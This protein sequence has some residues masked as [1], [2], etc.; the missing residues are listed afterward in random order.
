MLSQASPGASAFL[1]AVPSLPEVSLSTAEMRIS[2]R[3][4]LRLPVLKNIL[5]W[6]CTCSPTRHAPALWSD[7]LLTCRNEGMLGQR[8]D[9]LRRT[10]RG[11]ATTAGLI[12]EE[13]PRGLPGFG[14]GGGDLLVHDIH[15]GQAIVADVCVVSE[16]IDALAE[17]ASCLAG[18]AAKLAEHRK[19]QKYEP[20][21]QQLGLRFLPLAIESDGAFGKG[22]KEFI[23]HCNSIAHG[24]SHHR[25]HL[26]GVLLLLVLAPKNLSV[27]QK[28]DG[29]NSAEVPAVKLPR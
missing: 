22:H 27:P 25:Y 14:Q 10:L 18:H 2:L 16:H 12:S 5:S 3:R 23:A 28:G 1:S 7:H 26:G 6:P 9:N 13:Q 4:W 11:M 20:A 29:E 24:T 19:R 15:P 8:H 21:C 17:T